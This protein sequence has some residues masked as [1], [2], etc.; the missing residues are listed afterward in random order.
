MLDEMEIWERKDG[1]EFLQ[2][3]GIK[4][5]D[6]V[7]DFG[8]G[9]GHY[10]IPAAK[11]VG[12][13]GTVY[14]VDKRE[15]PL[16]K[17]LEKG[18]KH[19]LTNIKTIKNFNGLNL[20][21]ESM[22]IDYVLLFDILHYFEKGKRRKLYREVFR[23]LKQGGKLIVYPK[24]TEDDFPMG[25]FKGMNSEDV[26]GEIKEERFSFDEKICREIAHDEK[27]SHGCVFKFIKPDD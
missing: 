3:V 16:S 8:A 10:S 14:A 13:I 19:G 20:K 23:V 12:K 17:I 21:F 26:K 24:H 7:L 9:Y 22:S 6:T 15:E 5:G 11:V 18:S 27:L 4:P 1:P 25:E 2:R